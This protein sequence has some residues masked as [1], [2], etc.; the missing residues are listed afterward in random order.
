MIG[1]L[2]R[3]TQNATVI[4]MGP[5]AELDYE[6]LAKVRSLRAFQANHDSISTV[7]FHSFSDH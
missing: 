1:H 7:W 3:Q 4:T 2:M 5:F 6:I